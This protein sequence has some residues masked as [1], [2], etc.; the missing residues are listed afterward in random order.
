MESK[1][2][3]STGFMHEFGADEL[4]V[5]TTH[6]IAEIT[7]LEQE[8]S[9]F[10]SLISRY[11][12]PNIEKKNRLLIESLED[13]FKNLNIR[14]DQ[15]RKEIFAHQ[16]FLSTLLTETNPEIGPQI[17]ALHTHLEDRLSD[18]SKT[19]KQVKLE[20]FNATKFSGERKKV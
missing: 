20:F 15:L 8:I 9:Y 6:W 3:S 16:D 12:L 1:I 14:K 7:F 5:I 13:H 4:Y 11:F 10:Q 18:F 2:I 17:Y 19:L